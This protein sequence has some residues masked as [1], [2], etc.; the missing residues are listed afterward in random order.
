MIN[1]IPPKCEIKT[2]LEE[3][4]CKGNSNN[5]VIHYL[6]TCLSPRN[7]VGGDIVT[8]PFVGGWVREWVGE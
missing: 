5:V 8:L 7:R 1:L 6:F 3:L 4:S 2:I